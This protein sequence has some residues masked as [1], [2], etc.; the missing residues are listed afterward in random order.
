MF[1]FSLRDLLGMIVVAALSCLFGLL[2]A[3]PG[4]RFEL[5]AGVSVGIYGIGCYLAGVSVGKLS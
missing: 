3:Q 5:R 1:Q 2:L 4:E